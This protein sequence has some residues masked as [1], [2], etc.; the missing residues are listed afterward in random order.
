M[1]SFITQ[2]ELLINLSKMAY[3]TTILN[4]HVFITC[5]NDARIITS[6]NIIQQHTSNRLV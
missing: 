3:V 6:Q 1:F 5:L 2:T 4:I